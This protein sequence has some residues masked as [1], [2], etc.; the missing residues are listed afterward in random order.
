MVYN[1]S[2]WLLSVLIAVTFHKAAHGFVAHLLGDDSAWRLG[3][4]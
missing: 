1:I 4:N 3:K 2:I